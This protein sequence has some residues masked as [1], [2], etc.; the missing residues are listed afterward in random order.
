M[1]DIIDPAPLPERLLELT[2][3]ERAVL[4]VEA[5]HPAHSAAKEQAIRTRLGVSPVRFYQLLGRVSRSEAALAAE[6]MLVRR[7]LRLQAGP[8]ER[9]A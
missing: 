8:G 3:F 9:A 1:A 6:P 7:V 2:P 5:E 4:D